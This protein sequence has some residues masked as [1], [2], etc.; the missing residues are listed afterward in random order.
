[1]CRWQGVPDSG[2]IPTDWSW[3]YFGG[4]CEWSRY[5]VT[6]N[7]VEHGR[8]PMLRMNN[9]QNGKIDASDL[10]YIDLS[11]ADF[12]VHRLNPGELIVNRTNSYELVGKSA[13]IEEEADFVCASYIVRF[14]LR[15]D[16]A[17]P[18]FVNYFFNSYTGQ[19][20]LQILATKGV[21]QANINPTVLQKYFV[22]PLPPLPEQRKIAQILR[23]WDEAIATVEQLIAALQR[24]KKGLMQRLLTGQV[25]FPEFED[26]PWEE[27]ELGDYLTPVLRTEQ[28]EAGKEYRLIGVRWYLAGA[29]IHDVVP[30]DKIVTHAL[31]RMEENDI[32]YNKM[33]VSK[34][35][36]AVA[37]KEHAGAYG[38]GEY[39]QFI[40][41]DGI[42][43]RFIEYAFHDPRFLHDAK[44]LCRGTTGRIRLHP[45]DFLRLRM[46]LP[47]KAEQSKIAEVLRITDQ[48]I[49]AM[50]QY[51]NALRSQKKGLMQRLLT[52]Q[53]RVQ[54]DATSEVAE[55][56]PGAA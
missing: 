34:A 35:A 2:Q 8:Y 11:D 48:E 36:F 38:S 13:V 25:R 46:R 20:N 37:K 39:P 24:R 53:V 30:G 45:D 41:G 33:W 5:G 56:V 10:V 16:I 22:V 14:G 6:A 4:I 44:A 31:S 9:L 51:L 3:S 23:T 54:V 12:V 21:S 1:M 40:A 32:V 7:A 50:K 52:G 47:S 17:D 49:D 43:V 29:H 55:S 18:N 28:V 26:A 15:S 19:R 42:D 27:V